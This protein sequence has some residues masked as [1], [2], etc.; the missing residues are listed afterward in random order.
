MNSVLKC[1]LISGVVIFVLG[2]IIGVNLLCSCSNGS[3]L[4]SFGNNEQAS[5]QSEGS[6][7]SSYLDNIYSQLQG[8]QGGEVPLP[9]NELLLFKNNQFKPECCNQPQQ[10]SN[11]SGCACI[12]VEQMKYLNSRGGNNTLP[13]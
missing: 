1:N 10:Y 9:K 12:S 6:D 7:Q 3:L 13:N 11:S 2:I 4:E 8:N 5:V